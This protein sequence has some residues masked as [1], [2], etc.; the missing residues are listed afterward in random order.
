MSTFSTI[1]H[2]HYCMHMSCVHYRLYIL[3]L[4]YGIPRGVALTFRIR[5]ITVIKKSKHC[6]IFDKALEILKLIRKIHSFKFL[7]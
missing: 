4:N 7:T 5:R 1:L 2:L 6:C 3:V